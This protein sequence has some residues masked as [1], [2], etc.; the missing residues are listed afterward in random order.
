MTE[1]IL[2]SELRC[3]CCGEIIIDDAFLA[4][5]RLA[6]E[7]AGVP[8]VVTSGYR[9]ERHNK[10]V[11]S[12]SR[13]HVEGKAADISAIDGPTRGKILK[14]LYKAGFERVGIARTFIHC[15]TMDAVESCWLY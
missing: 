11:G 2:L 4:R 6:R 14:G 5:L 8:F 9:C 12:S 3:P 7:I 10:E 15:D 1:K 13:N